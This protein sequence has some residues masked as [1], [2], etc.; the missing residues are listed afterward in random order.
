MWST[1]Q[2]VPSW[3]EYVTSILKWRLGSDRNK[4]KWIIKPLQGQCNQF[5]LLQKVLMPYSSKLPVQL[6][7]LRYDWYVSW[8]NSF[9]EIDLYMNRRKRKRQRGKDLKSSYPFRGHIPRQ[10][11]YGFSI[12]FK[13]YTTSYII[14][15]KRAF[16]STKRT[17]PQYH[18]KNIFWSLLYI[19]ASIWIYLTYKLYILLTIMSWMFMMNCNMY[20]IESKFLPVEL[21]Q[22]MDDILK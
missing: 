8:Y 11:I 19:Q 12:F 6:K 7:I 15:W 14:S 20:I 5:H 21:K 10:E 16:I 9:R 4:T 17:A 1:T 3:K 13:P 22:N 18:Q 2:A